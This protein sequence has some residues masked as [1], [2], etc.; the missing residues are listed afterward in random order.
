MCRGAHS[1]LTDFS[2]MP[3]AAA[4]C[5]LDRLGPG[6]GLQQFVQGAWKPFIASDLNGSALQVS[7]LLLDR[8]NALWVGTT[9]QGIYRVYDGGVD[10]FRSPD[11]LSSNSVN[12]FYE[13]REGN[14]WVAGSGGIDCF[15]DTRVVSFSTREGLSANQVGAVLASRGGTIRVGMTVLW[16]RSGI[17]A[18][19]PF[20]KGKAYHGTESGRC[21]K[22][23]LAT[24]GSALT[25][26]YSST[27]SR[28]SGRFDVAKAL[29]QGRPSP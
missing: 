5:G 14:L 29:Q 24:C 18:C 26:D 13:D 23:M 3:V 12:S 27:K 19:L 8:E 16:I 9:D 4:H 6:L 7:A 28:S 15:R 17:G 2:G 10:R 11:G 1:L 21:L 22:I 20:G 25:T